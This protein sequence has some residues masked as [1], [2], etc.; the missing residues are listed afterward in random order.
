MNILREKNIDLKQRTA[1]ESCINYYPGESVSFWGGE[2]IQISNKPLETLKT[3]SKY[4]KIA[5]EET[6]E[7]MQETV[8][9]LQDEIESL[10]DQLKDEKEESHNWNR[11]YH[12]QIQRGDSFRNKF[13][14]MERQNE[15]L[16]QQLEIETANR[17]SADK[18][19]DDSLIVAYRDELLTVE[20]MRKVVQMAERA[21]GEC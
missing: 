11:Q 14:D 6:F 4:V 13:L 21:K 12:E 19:A 15:K 18:R 9:E 17:K 7:I 5:Y 2:S 3:D 16:K 1:S 8:K 10:T 20:V